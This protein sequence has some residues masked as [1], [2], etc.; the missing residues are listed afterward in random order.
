VSLH[1]NITYFDVIIFYLRLAGQ[2]CY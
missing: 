2:S 1:V